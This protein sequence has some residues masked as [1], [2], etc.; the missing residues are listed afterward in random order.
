MD[1]GLQGRHAFVA[2]STSGLG[3][4]SAAALAEAGAAV[5]ISGRRVELAQQEAAKIERAWAVELDLG[6]PTSITA[7]LT[8]A[9]DR[10]GP[11]DVL[12]VNGGGPPPG[13]ANELAPGDIEELTRLLVVPHQ[14][15]IAEVLPGMRQRG[16][17]R[18]I[19]LGSSGVQEPI[20][21]L[22]RSNI[23][24]AALAGLLKSLSRE[25][26]VDGVTVNMVL[27]GRIRTDRTAAL[28]ASNAQRTG[29]TPAEVEA[30]SVASIPAGRYGDPAEF[31]AAVA[32]LASAR[33]SY[34]TG[35]QLRVD[36]GAARGF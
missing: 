23:G 2:A 28:D 9:I 4:A 18:I 27:P 6:D 21:G 3:L 29:R 17:G 7:A 1:L 36:G 31:G 8:A 34:I 14:Q 12:V 30:A 25:V 20:D 35:V 5:T 32:M 15:M 13:P 24:R 11:I 10:N 19:A 33:A 22:A 26:A 16:W